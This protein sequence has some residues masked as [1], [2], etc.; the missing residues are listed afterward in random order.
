MRS[1]CRRRLL[2]L[3]SWYPGPRSWKRTVG[4]DSRPPLSS[5]AARQVAPVRPLLGTAEATHPPVVQ[6][7]GEAGLDALAERPVVAT[8]LHGAPGCQWWSSAL[9]GPGC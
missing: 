9:L 8:G 3:D 5:Q 7:P 6:R 1:R 2:I 4:S